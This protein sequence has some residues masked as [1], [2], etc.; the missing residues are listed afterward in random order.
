MMIKVGDEYLDFDDDIIVE[1]SA[2]L[3]QSISENRG[4]FSYSSTA[5][6]TSKNEKLLKLFSLNQ[7]DKI[8]NTKID[9]GIYDDSGNLIYNGF[10]QITALD[11]KDVEFT[12]FSGNTDWFTQITGTLYDLNLSEFDTENTISNITSTWGNKSGVVF[13]IVD[14]GVLSKATSNRLVKNESLDFE[15]NDFKPFLYVKDL[16]NKIMV[17]NNLKISG[18]LIND[19]VYNKLIFTSN[20]TRIPKER[21]D[22]NTAKVG[23]LTAQS[24]TTT[25]ATLELVDTDPFFDGS[26]NNWDNTLFR[27]TANAEMRVSITPDFSFSVSQQY[28]LDIYK[29]GVLI[30]SAYIPKTTTGLPISMSVGDYLDFQLSA[31]STTANLKTNSSITIAPE[32][33]N[34]IYTSDFM[35]DVSQLQF[36]S[37][38]FKMFNVVTNYDSYSKT[39]NT[40]LFKN[41]KNRSEIDLSEYVN[42]YRIE[43]TTLLDNF[44]KKNFFLYTEQDLKEVESYNVSNPT[45]LG[46][47]FIDIDND[48]L[49]D[50]GTIL[51][52]DAISPYSYF[53]DAFQMWMINLN[54]LETSRGQEREITSVTNNAGIARFNYT[55]NA[56]GIFSNAVIEI[57]DTDDENYRGIGIVSTGAPGY[58]EV[59]GL[60]Y[61]SNTTGYFTVMSYNPIDSPLPIFAIHLPGLNVN[62]F[63]SL[64][65]FYINGTEYT[66]ADYAYF[67]KPRLQLS[68]D[69]E[70][71]SLSF[72]DGNE[73]EDYQIS[74]ITNY[75]GDLI[76]ILNDSQIV[77]VDAIIPFNIYNQLDFFSPI[78]IKNKNFN[79]QFY[80]NRITGYVNSYTSCTLELIKLP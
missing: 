34:N 3:I 50:S 40:I 9:A 54:Y 79:S 49:D 47:G 12:F 75:Y 55:G 14:K 27:F 57:Y 53:N 33:F 74:L 60:S 70:L 52:L 24:I 30:R 76:G 5:P 72:G 32:S 17:Q 36:I 80:L 78:R 63:S 46:G 58:V 39:I 56:E 31:A 26:N 61:I 42:D 28:Q 25:P 4:D 65:S 18:E 6:R 77:I 48:I 73:V 23:R 20:P 66:L 22:A 29:N 11:S 37:T 10:I 69:S 7:S 38:I 68:I 44:F 41:I 51:E 16:I 13:P 59:R 62:Q 19:P 2:K 21:I 43:Y 45:P 67:Y 8:F 71:F 64:E 15:F 1:K 35:P